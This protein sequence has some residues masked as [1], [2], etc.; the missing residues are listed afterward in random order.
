MKYLIQT[1][2]YNNIKKYNFWRDKLVILDSSK[3]IKINNKEINY[4]ND[5]YLCK[6]L[7]IYSKND[8]GNLCIIQNQNEINLEGNFY[9]GS[10]IFFEHY[11]MIRQIFDPY[12]YQNMYWYKCS[13]QTFSVLPTKYFIYE[14]SEI[15]ISLVNRSLVQGSKSGDKQLW[16]TDIS[17]YG[18]KRYNHRNEAIDSSTP[19]TISGE[20]MGYEDTIV[21]PLSGKQTLALNIN[22]GSLK[23]IK[24]LSASNL[25]KQC[26]DKLYY[27]FWGEIIE[28][29]IH[30]GEMTRK[31]NLN[32][33]LKK[34]D[35]SLFTNY[36]SNGKMLLDFNNNYSNILVIDLETL[37]IE[38]YIE[39]EYRSKMLRVQTGDTIWHD[40]KVYAKDML[41][42]T[43]YVYG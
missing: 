42:N 11:F 40:H 20:V 2:V 21:V 37:T 10:I 5:F 27:Y 18:Q 31:L 32:D 12:D 29:K 33:F 24:E 39:N 30:T 13:L 15:Q 26:K 28:V 14:F 34:I 9:L 3:V 16:Q 6:D 17:H 35:D 22:D 19:N 4:V 7:V 36:I 1:L 43:L 8:F 25:L 38:S 23:W 41:T